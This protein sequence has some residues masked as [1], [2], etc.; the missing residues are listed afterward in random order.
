MKLKFPQ[1]LESFNVAQRQSWVVVTETAYR[2]AH[3]RKSL[4]K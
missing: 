2:L 1:S 4:A 3:G